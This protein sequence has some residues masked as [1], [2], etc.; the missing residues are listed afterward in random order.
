MHFLKKGVLPQLCSS[1][2]FSICPVLRVPM[3]VHDPIFCAFLKLLST[4][5][6]S[7]SFNTI[8]F[9]N[10]ASFDDKLNCV[11]MFFTDLFTY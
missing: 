11:E 9:L 10:C 6:W 3:S 8:S 5:L 2:R 1:T 7:Q 4:Y